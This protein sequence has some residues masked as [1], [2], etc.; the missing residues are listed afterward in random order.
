MIFLFV[1]L[2]LLAGAMECSPPVR[3]PHPYDTQ[4]ACEEVLDQMLDKQDGSATDG[5]VAFMLQCAGET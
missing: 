4:T 2:C 5:P 1:K 3:I